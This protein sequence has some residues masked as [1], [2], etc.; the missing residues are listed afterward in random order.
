MALSARARDALDD[1]LAEL[2]Y[3]G[4]TTG[5]IRQRRWCI[6]RLA[7][8]AD[9]TDVLDLDH[10]A[11]VAFGGRDHL[12]AETRASELVHL[13]GYYGWCAREGVVEVDPTIRLP[14]PARPRR[15]PRPIPTSALD[16]AMVDAPHPVREW[17]ALAAYGGLRR[18][19]IVW[20]AGEDYDPNRGLLRIRAQKGGGEG[21]IVV[22]DLLARELAGLPR[23]GWWWPGRDGSRPIHPVTLGTRA[24]RWLAETAG[25]GWTLH[26]LRHWH[27]TTALEHARDL[28]VV[29][30]ML[31]HASPVATA[32]YT[33]VPEREIRAALAEFPAL[34]GRRA[35]YLS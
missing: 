7:R 11:L 28:R 16:T 34:A 29:Q 17:L 26:T 12:A 20:L 14:R 35:K 19:E 33:A 13:R 30:E 6:G 1:H 22:E 9:P 21:M 31:R 5:T 3:R 10:H 23:S 32:W 4:R 15:L 8:W 18:V 25:T 24:N 27:A 2:A